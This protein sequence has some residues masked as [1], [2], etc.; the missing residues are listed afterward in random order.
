[1][2]SRRW[3]TLIARLDWQTEIDGGQ[4]VVSGSAQ[5]SSRQAH[6]VYNPSKRAEFMR[7]FARLAANETLARTSW[8]HSLAPWA[9]RA[10]TTAIEFLSDQRVRLA[11]TQRDRQVVG[12]RMR[13]NDEQAGMT[14]RPERSE[15]PY[16]DSLSWKTRSGAS[17]THLYSNDFVEFASW[18]WPHSSIRELPTPDSNTHSASGTLPAEWL[19]DWNSPTRSSDLCEERRF[20]TTLD[21]DR[22]RTFQEEALATD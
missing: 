4:V 11:S 19:R 18:L 17:L 13:T 14:C 15:I 20:Y 12:Y 1:M 10:E 8:K 9:S 22:F 6:R 3:G 21:T 7:I 2:T 5:P 16:T